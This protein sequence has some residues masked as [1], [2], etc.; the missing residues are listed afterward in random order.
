M[1]KCDRG[2]QNESTQVAKKKILFQFLQ[3]S[4]YVDT[5]YHPPILRKIQ[6]HIL[7]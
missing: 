5:L 7:P 4:E 3:T 2:Q 6:L 1:L